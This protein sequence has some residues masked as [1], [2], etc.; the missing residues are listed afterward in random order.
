MTEKK[1]PDVLKDTAFDDQDFVPKE[2]IQDKSSLLHAIFFSMNKNDYQKKNNDIEKKNI[3]E[4]YRSRLASKY[5]RAEEKKESN[6]LNMYYSTFFDKNNTNS[7][8]NSILQKNRDYLENPEKEFRLDLL[9]LFEV[10]DNEKTKVIIINVDNTYNTFKCMMTSEK[11][12]EKYRKV[13]FVLLKDGVYYSLV[14]KDVN[15]SYHSALDIERKQTIKLLKICNENRE[16]INLSNSNYEPNSY[17]KNNALITKT[18]IKFNISKYN[19]SN[20]IKTP[21]QYKIKSTPYSLFNYKNKNK[22]DVNLMTF[23]LIILI[24]IVIYFI[25]FL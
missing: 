3:I 9:K 1:L 24:A 12:K 6:K 5:Y 19:V 23:I 15:T 17:K 20:K 8:N 13:V 11:D 16:I 10:F 22:K 7:S 14:E 4:E 18:N 21:N 2:I 25:Y